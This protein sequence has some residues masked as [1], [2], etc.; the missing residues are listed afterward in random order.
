[1][2]SFLSSEFTFILYEKPVRARS[3]PAISLLPA[4]PA[5]GPPG[6]PWQILSLAMN[7]IFQEKWW[8]AKMSYLERG[9][10]FG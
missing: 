8:L 2:I 9:H 1:M 3:V 4:T 10:R 6:Q 5:Q 7:E